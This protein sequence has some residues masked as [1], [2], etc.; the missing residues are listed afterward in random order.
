MLFGEAEA[1]G[2]VRKLTFVIFW[3]VTET[4]ESQNDVQEE[5]H[6]Y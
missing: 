4:V 2:F 6:I 5:G 3:S 1:C